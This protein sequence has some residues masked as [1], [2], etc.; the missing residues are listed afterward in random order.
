[1]FVYFLSAT[2]SS[3]SYVLQLSNSVRV[4][5]ESPQ[6]EFDSDRCCSGFLITGTNATIGLENGEWELNTSE[7]NYDCEKLERT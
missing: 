2:C 5:R 3:P 6:Q 1:M 7:M 4:I